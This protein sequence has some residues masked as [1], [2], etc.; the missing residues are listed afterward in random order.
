MVNLFAAADAMILETA[1]QWVAAGCFQCEQVEI[2]K[3]REVKV[4]RT[5]KPEIFSTSI[6]KEDEWDLEA[7]AIINE[8]SDFAPGSAERIDDLRAFYSNPQNEGKSSCV[9]TDD[10]EAE[11]LLTALVNTRETK[12]TQLTLALIA[13]LQDCRE[14]VEDELVA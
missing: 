3:G 8:L 13:A 6:E 9:L 11:R 1:K 12:Q 14:A 4:L 2:R 7:D 5:V 10:E